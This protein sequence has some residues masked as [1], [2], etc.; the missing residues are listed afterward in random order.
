MY[1]YILSAVV[2]AVLSWIPILL[3]T[4][5]SNRRASRRAAILTESFQADLL[6]HESF[7]DVHGTVNEYAEAIRETPVLGPPRVEDALVAYIRDILELYRSIEEAPGHIAAAEANDESKLIRF[8]RSHSE[9]YDD[10]R[11]QISGC[12]RVVLQRLINKGF[13]RLL[14]LRN[15]F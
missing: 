15:H 2:G 14:G 8:R 5:E 11:K 13:N 1:E 9:L 4:H 3:Q 6:N 7:A 12:D 10:L